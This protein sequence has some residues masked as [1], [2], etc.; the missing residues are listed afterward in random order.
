MTR[1]CGPGRISSHLG[2]AGLLDH[3]PLG[4]LFTRNRV[5][6]EVNRECARLLGYAIEELIGQPAAMIYPDEGIHQALALEAAPTLAAGKVFHAETELVRKDG[7]RFWCR[8]QARA[9]D[10]ARPGQGTLWFLEDVSDERQMQEALEHSNRVFGALFSST[11]MAVLYVRERTILRYNRQLETLFGFPHDSVAGVSTRILFD[12]EEDYRRFGRETYPHL[13]H[14][15]ASTH[16]VRHLPDGE[17]LQLRVFGTALDADEPDVGS[18]WFI[19]DVTALHEA[20][21]KLRQAYAEQQA[22][23]DNAAIGIVLARDRVIL[24]CNPWLAPVTGYDPEEL[25]GR[26]SRVLYRSETDYQRVGAVFAEAF[27]SGEPAINE[28]PLR[29]RD[30][31]SFWARITSRRIEGTDSDV[32]SIIED[33]SEQHKAEQALLDMRQQLEVRVAERTAELE[34]VV[35]QLQQEVFER[36]QAERRIWEM[37]HHD[38]LTGLPNRALLHDRLARALEQAQREKKRTA[39]MFIDLDRFKSI[40]DTLGHAVG[41]ELLQH[42]AQRLKT[43]VRGVDTISRLGGDEFV[44]VLHEIASVDDA[45]LVAEKILVALATPMVIGGNPIHVTPSIGI[46]V[47]PEDGTEVLLLMKNADTAMYHAKAAGRNNFQFF[48]RQMNEQ[49]SRF[50]EME[51]RL[52]QA[53]SAGELILHYQPLIDWTSRAVCGMEVLV[54]W[55]DP[56]HGL[57]SPAEFIP[58]AEETGLIIPLGE[59]VLAHALQQNRQWQQQGRPLLPLS[60][61]LSPRQF[62]QKDL[63]DSIRRLLAETGQPANLLELELTES[64]LMHDVSETT[65]RLHELAAMGVSIAIDDFG[66]GYSS[67]AYLK[68][69]PVHKLKVDQSFVRDLTTD[70]DDVAIV[71][72]VIGLAA[73]MRLDLVAEGVERTEQLEVLLGMGCRKFQGYLFSWPLPASAADDIFSPPFLKTN[74]F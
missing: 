70:A 15:A 40:N 31:S 28:L 8:M 62:R 60:V 50:F 2:L 66:T 72:S 53:I 55:N 36:M 47:Y 68:R 69:F 44:V 48:S 22:I 4:I 6:C 25:I 16:V 51:Q 64:S 32:I 38:G 63:V 23:F 43:L 7:R 19:E 13:R 26:S 21:Q 42:V 34:T 52:R 11:A 18:I 9:I 1:L 29:R 37:A 61:N 54:R 10:P 67:L 5:F 56:Q 45:V 24:R 58:V 12:N 65:N 74:G 27:A 71:T 3:A 35:A 17:V 49:A 46:A 73:S 41:D 14:G 39:A 57:I 30:G 20:E 33:I 59:W